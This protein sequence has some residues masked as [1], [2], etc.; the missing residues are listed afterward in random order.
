[1]PVHDAL[2][3]TDD[4]L[5][6]VLAHTQ[7]VAHRLIVVDDASDPHVAE[8]L[9][10][11]DRRVEVVRNDVN[12]GFVRTA[13]RG[14]TLTRAP[15]VCLLNSDTIVTPG[16]LSRLLRCA[17]SDPRI[18]VV[19]PITNSAANL[20]VPMAPGLDLFANA[21]RIAAV[22]RRDYPDIVTAVGFC[23]LVTR[24]AL[25][26]FGGFDEVYDRGYCEESDYCMRVMQ[27]GLRVVAAD[28]AFVF[29]R[30]G[31]SFGAQARARYLKNRAIFD[32]RWGS[33]YEVAYPAFLR[34]DP[35]GYLRA[36]LVEG[37]LPAAEPLPAPPP[38]PRLG[39]FERLWVM[40]ADAWRRGGAVGLARKAPL[41]PRRLYEALR[42]RRHA[43]RASGQPPPPPPDSLTGWR[44]HATRDYTARL[45]RGRGLRIAVL[46]WRLE[47]CGGVLA[48]VD[49]MNWLIL[50]GHTVIPVTVGEE[51]PLNLL[52]LYARPLTF[53]TAD[54]LA[55]AFPEVD[56]VLATFWPTAVDWLPRVRARWPRTPAVY[57]LQDYEPWFYPGDAQADLRARIVASYS[58]VDARIVTTAWLRA[59]VAEHGH[60]SEVIPIG[61]DGRVFFRRAPAAR[62]PLRRVLTQARPAA[63]WR[64]FDLALATFTALARRRRDVQAVLFGC[65]DAELQ[66]QAL[67]FEWTNA[68]VVDDR[69]AVARLMASCDAVLD[70]SRF[71]AFGLPGLEAMACGV[72]A[73]LPD[74]GGIV[75][76]ARHDVNALLA[77]PEDI[78]GRADAL[79]R[80]LD[81]GALR[82][83]LIAAGLE[84]AARYSHA[85]VAR[86]HLDVYRRVVASSR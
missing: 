23:F 80:L 69:N 48:L 29:H 24:V 62:G 86:R 73:L 76:Y 17:A 33:A 60:D 39:P 75:E 68:G 71:Q 66:G 58:S 31:A 77:D 37:S 7:D 19:N 28:D 1:M 81:D 13:N 56:V 34:R 49:L 78:E 22:S 8:R 27:A 32:A 63:P 12:Q 79:E 30:G 41:A 42:T 10:A 52:G 85:D 44:R 50:A 59:K 40:T 38:P 45:P 74:R 72:P 21:A 26:R 83:R 55:E 9:R 6:S 46:V 5:R 3:A 61:V 14:L 43:P 15:F 54:D 4:C 35:L 18:A 82:E 70:A 64:G 36:A 11:I 47:V 25:D 16:W 53:R 84:T 2:D 67:A 57:F 20:S 65:A 51:P